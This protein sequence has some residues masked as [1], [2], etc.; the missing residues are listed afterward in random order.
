[1]HRVIRMWSRR[2]PSLL[3]AMVL[4]TTPI[5]AK[6]AGQTQLTQSVMRQKL[7]ASQQLLAALVTSN[8]AAL[9]RHSRTLQALT[10]QPGWDVMRLP[11]Y[12]THTIAF[13]R[14]VQALTDAAGQRDQTTALAAYNGLVSSCVECHR[15]VARARIADTTQ[16][17]RR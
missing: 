9:D 8:W 14:A 7:A 2:L 11:E 10:N 16:G 4:L 13:Q 15:Y 17:G 12:R 6:A 1:M 5:P 3:G